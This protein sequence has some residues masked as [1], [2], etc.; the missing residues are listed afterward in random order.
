MDKIE[1]FIN[2]EETLKAMV[3]SRQLQEIVLK[4]R[5]K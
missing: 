3:S 5:R 4:K 2:H 1:E